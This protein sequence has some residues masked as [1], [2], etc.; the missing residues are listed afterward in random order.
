M[1]VQDFEKAIDALNCGIFIDEMVIGKGNQVKA[2]Y[3]HS[4]HR[5]HKWDEL[6][7]GFVDYS[8]KEKTLPDDE[9]LDPR[10]EV[11]QWER[12]NIYDLEFE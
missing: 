6:G 7:R 10:N 12:F 4:L 9:P 1:K 5:C 3:G 8:Q 11:D 2:C